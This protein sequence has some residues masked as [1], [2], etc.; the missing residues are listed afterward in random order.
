MNNQ[1]LL[2]LEQKVSDEFTID[3][4][5]MVAITDILMFEKIKDG[6]PVAEVD[7]KY[8]T[9]IIKIHAVISHNLGTALVSPLPYVRK[10]A[11]FISK[12]KLEEKKS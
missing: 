3:Q 9:D 11:N 5:N 4:Q 7:K 8:V 10:W 12:E 6:V 2:D 1:F